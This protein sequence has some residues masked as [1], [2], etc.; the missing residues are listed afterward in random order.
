MFHEDI[1][2][3]CDS[4]SDWCLAKKASHLVLKPCVDKN[5]TPTIPTK[6]TIDL[7]MDPSIKTVTYSTL[8]L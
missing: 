5:P 4:V 7:T 2:I 3:I 1:C 6:M 8:L